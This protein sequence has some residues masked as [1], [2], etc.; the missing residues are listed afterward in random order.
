MTDAG[1]HPANFRSRRQ[2]PLFLMV[3][4]LCLMLISIF[5]TWFGVPADVQLTVLGVGFVTFVIGGVTA[6]LWR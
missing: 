1:N 2:Y 4:G 3:I 6:M 5:V